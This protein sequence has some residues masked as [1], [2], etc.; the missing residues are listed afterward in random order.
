MFY[1]RR[2]EKSVSDS[3]VLLNLELSENRRNIDLGAK[4]GKPVFPVK[5]VRQFEG[6]DVMQGLFR[7]SVFMDRPGEYLFFVLGSA[8]DKKGLLGK[9]YDFGMD[10]PVK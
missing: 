1:V 7:L 10:L 8:D 5:S 9:G 2:S 4:S 3:L 6:E